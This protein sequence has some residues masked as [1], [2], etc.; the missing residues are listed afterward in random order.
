MNENLI[1]ALLFYIAHLR[2]KRAT[3]PHTKIFI[4]LFSL[5][6]N[7]FSL[8]IGIFSSSCFFPLF[9]ATLP[10]FVV[11]ILLIFVSFCAN[12]HNFLSSL[13]GLKRGA[14]KSKFTCRWFLSFWVDFSSAKLVFV[15]GSD[16]ID[17]VNFLLS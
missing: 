6:T 5:W 11:V 17:R 3:P 12:H 9:R 1:A 14:R 4:A 16:W 7:S 2:P 15:Q 10:H 13:G 8:N